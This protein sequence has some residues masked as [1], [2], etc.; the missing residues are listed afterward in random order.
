[1]VRKRIRSYRVG[2]QADVK[3]W[4]NA[5]SGVPAFLIGKGPSLDGADLSC[6]KPFFTIGINRAF[7][8]LDPTILLWQDAELWWNHRAEIQRLKAV[9]YCR[10][11]SDPQSRCYHF[12]LEGNDYRLP[13]SPSALYGRGASGHPQRRQHHDYV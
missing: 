5:L 9:K 10:N 4:H 11:I 13:E 12:S 1:M 2:N 3:G 7:F 8:L 6:L